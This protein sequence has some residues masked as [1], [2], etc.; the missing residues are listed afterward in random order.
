MTAAA[1]VD[2]EQPPVV[3]RARPGA[4]RGGSAGPPPRPETTSTSTPASAG[5]RR[6]NSPG[7][8]PRAR[9]WW[10]PPAPAHRGVG[11]LAECGRARRRR[12]RWLVGEQLHVAAAVP[13]RTISFSR[14]TT[15]KLA[16][17]RRCG[18]RRGGGELVPTSTAASVSVTESDPA[19]VDAVEQTVAERGDALERRAPPRP[20]FVSPSRLNCRNAVDA[21]VEIA[22]RQHEAALEVWRSGSVL[23]VQP[24]VRQSACNERSLPAMLMPR[25]NCMASD[26]NVG[27]EHRHGEVADPRTPRPTRV[28]WS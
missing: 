18:P 23:A 16:R 24:P 10:P 28:S 15:S 6:T 5:A 21:L 26:H 27:Q 14:A 8:R 20:G 3:H 17:P 13:R 4:R 2:E 22:G 7:S 12:G 25:R 19:G 11:D 1:D 9:R